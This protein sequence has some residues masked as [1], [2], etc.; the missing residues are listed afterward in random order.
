MA[1]AH[2][3]GYIQPEAAMSHNI[4]ILDNSCCGY[5]KKAISYY[6]VQLTFI[7]ETFGY[8]L[9]YKGYRKNEEK[10]QRIED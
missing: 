2:A 1:R 6:T 5:L 7:I 4:H 9:E 10:C 8:S 3:G